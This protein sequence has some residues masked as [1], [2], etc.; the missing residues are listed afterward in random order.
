MAKGRFFKIKV[1]K[2]GKEY[3]SFHSD[4][5]SML[6]YLIEEIGRQI[7]LHSSVVNVLE[8]LHELIQNY[9]LEWF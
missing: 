3:S 1:K 6:L 5:L 2:L 4:L 8:M 9:V 7:C